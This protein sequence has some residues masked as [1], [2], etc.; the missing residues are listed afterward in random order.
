MPGPEDFY[1][2]NGKDLPNSSKNKNRKMPTANTIRFASTQYIR[3]GQP[4]F[5]YVTDKSKYY[6]NVHPAMTRYE[7]LN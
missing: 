5:S 6:D 1:Q 7:V 4:V 2:K 3:A